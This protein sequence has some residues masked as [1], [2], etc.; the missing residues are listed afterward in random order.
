VAPL[1]AFGIALLGLA[2]L[3]AWALA[4]RRDDQRRR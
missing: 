4:H 2:G 1:I 3:E